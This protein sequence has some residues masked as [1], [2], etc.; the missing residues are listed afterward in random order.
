MSKVARHS[1]DARFGDAAEIDRHQL[2]FD[3][4]ARPAI[5]PVARVG[6]IPGD[7]EL[8]RQQSRS[9]RLILK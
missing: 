8:R 6:R 9:P 1:R 7:E 5:D 2:P 3:D 4:A